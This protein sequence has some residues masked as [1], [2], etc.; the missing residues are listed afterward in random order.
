[1]GSP[2]KYCL[3][4]IGFETFRTIWSPGYSFPKLNVDIS[5]NFKQKWAHNYKVINYEVYKLFRV[6]MRNLDLS[7]VTLYLVIWSPLEQSVLTW[8]LL[9]A[10]DCCSV[11]LNITELSYHSEFSCKVWVHLIKWSSGNLFEFACK[12]VRST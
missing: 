11:L 4:L 3:L 6:L 9:S 8:L 5:S 2:S 12:D 7:Q 10:P 1:M